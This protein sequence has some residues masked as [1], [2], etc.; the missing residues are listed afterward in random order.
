[1]SH[2]LDRAVCNALTTRL[3]AFTTPDS[4]AH[5]VRIDPEVGVFLACADD[6]PDSVIARADSA[7]YAAKRMGRDRVIPDRR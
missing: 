6:T 2:P 3:S 7:L 5:A 4:N 1:M